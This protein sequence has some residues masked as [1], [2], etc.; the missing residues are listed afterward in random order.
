MP[1]TRAVTVNCSPT[2]GVSEW[3][4]LA[5][6]IVR[7]HQLE[8]GAG[9]RVLVVVNIAN[10][11]GFIGDTLAQA[12]TASAEELASIKIACFGRFKSL[13]SEV[14]DLKRQPFTALKRHRLI[15]LLLPSV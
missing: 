14:W 12:C 8:A 13:V 7:H 5:S 10:A 9:G 2:W 11:I 4:G 1:L 15:L 6:I 3:Q